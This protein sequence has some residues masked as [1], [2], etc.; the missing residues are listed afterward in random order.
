LGRRGFQIRF[1]PE[2]S[3]LHLKVERYFQ[4]YLMMDSDERDVEDRKETDL[5]LRSDEHF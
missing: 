2:A 5:L 4:S 1:K 3:R